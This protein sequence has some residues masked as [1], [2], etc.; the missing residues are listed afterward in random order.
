MV[1][2]EIRWIDSAD[3]C[4]QS[5]GLVD[6]SEWKPLLLS[7]VYIC[8]F[9]TIGEPGVRGA[10][11][12]QLVVATPEGIQKCR[13]DTALDEMLQSFK[14]CYPGT[15]LPESMKTFD[16]GSSWGPLLI[17]DGWNWEDVHSQLE[18][19]VAACERETW[20]ESLECLRKKFW[21]EYEGMIRKV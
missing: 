21:W 10:A 2:P 11:L 12:F 19:R 15:P 4:D 14:E 7:D 5:G 9:L 20:D 16:V 17:V 3:T 18:H 8:V 13:P 1:R 6:I